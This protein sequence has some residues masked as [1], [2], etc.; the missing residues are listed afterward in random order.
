MYVTY[1]KA[2]VLYKNVRKIDFKIL[3]K[4]CGDFFECVLEKNADLLTFFSCALEYL[5]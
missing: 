3:I 4:N 2:V 1:Y 5:E